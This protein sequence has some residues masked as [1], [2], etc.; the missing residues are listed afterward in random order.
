MNVSG[1][2][3]TLKLQGDV[4]PD[5]MI[6][7]SNYEIL[8]TQDSL[9]NI[10]NATSILLGRK[11]NQSE[12]SSI[13]N[14]IARLPATQLYEQPY[15]KCISLI[16]RNFINR[17]AVQLGSVQEQDRDTVLSGVS[18]DTDSGTISEYERK[19]LAQLTSNENSY[20]FTAHQN[21]RGDSV[22]DKE[23]VAGRRGSPNNLLPVNRDENQ[24]MV[25]T[26]LYKTMLLL[27]NLLS[28]E[29][30]ESMFSRIQTIGTNF[31][32]INLVHQII[33][34]DSR[35]RLPV[36]FNVNEFSWDVHTAGKPGQ[37]GAVRVLDT[38]HQII[39]LRAYPFWVP[40]N[41][42]TSNPYAKI[43]LLIRE[44]SA[45]SVTVS[46][47][48]D[49][50][51]SVPTTNNYH[52]EF[53]VQDVKGDRMYLVPKQDTY[54]FRKPINVM[55]RITTQFFTP[56]EG[57]VFDPDFGTYTVFYGN[58]TLFN[59]TNPAAHLLNTGDLTYVY[60]SNSGDADADDAITRTSG[61]YITKTGPATFTIPL[62][63]ST[64][65]GSE[66][67]VRVYYGSK[68]VC[69]ELEFI[70]LEQ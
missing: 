23:R 10:A 62:D 63:T 40:V 14:F 42:S 22:I 17:H 70:C 69:F 38:V 19:E 2:K 49:P 7:P 37:L 1:R 59:I 20:K 54:S 24:H 32:N 13:V 6:L 33:Q 68:R 43:R 47:F 25:N 61:W 8:L 56:F 29:S 51:Q 45:Q 15:S 52:F 50:D 39:Q 27:Q 34:F 21:R 60:N 48:N 28:P 31:Y 67:N 5:T 9:R 64:L 26:E 55:D 57:E 41:N 3:K 53:E 35:N 16:A 58:P 44:F 4:P 11:L 46:E 12:V 36:T 30:T 18:G 66:S 65:V